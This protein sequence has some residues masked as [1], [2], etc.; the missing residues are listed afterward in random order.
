M[1][2]RDIADRLQID[3]IES[4][5]RKPKRSRV[6]GELKFLQ[7][8]LADSGYKISGKKLQSLATKSKTYESFILSAMRTV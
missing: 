7:K 4:P 6:G 2:I 5:R 8:V 3:L 1:K